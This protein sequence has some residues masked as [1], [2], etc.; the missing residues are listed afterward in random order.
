M[1]Q[2]T[3]LV[4]ESAVN[5][6]GIR[7]TFKQ[8]G[9]GLVTNNKIWSTGSEALGYHQEKSKVR[10]KGDGHQNKCKSTHKTNLKIQKL[11]SNQ[12]R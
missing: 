11:N 9:D 4:T 7:A 1:L 8:A 12:T 6:R 10:G 2:T 5:S 3:R